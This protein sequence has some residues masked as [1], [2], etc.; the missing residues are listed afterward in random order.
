LAREDGGELP[1]V[2]KSHG[3]GGSVLDHMILVKT[4]PFGFTMTPDFTAIRAAF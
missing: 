2:T 3:D 4:Y 1:A